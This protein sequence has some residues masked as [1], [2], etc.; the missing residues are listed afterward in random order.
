MQPKIG[1]GSEFWQY[2]IV[3]RFE[4][5][6]RLRVLLFSSTNAQIVNVGHLSDPS[7]PPARPHHLIG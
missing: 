5:V 3:V 4:N 2:A 1:Q 7:G 6:T